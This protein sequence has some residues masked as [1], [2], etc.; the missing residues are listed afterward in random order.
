MNLALS[1]L[2]DNAQHRI[3]ASRAQRT[4]SAERPS[5]DGGMRTCTSCFLLDGG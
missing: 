2:N 3:A 4:R 1:A 5:G